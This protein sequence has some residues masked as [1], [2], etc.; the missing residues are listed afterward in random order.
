MATYRLNGEEKRW[1]GAEEKMAQ[2]I[3]AEATDLKISRTYNRL[4]TYVTADQPTDTV[5]KA[6]NQGLELLPL[7]HPNNLYAQ[8][9]TRFKVLLDGKPVADSKI[10]VISGGVR[11]RG[12]LKYRVPI[13]V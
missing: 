1:R 8:E 6:V 12:V 7:S 3:P 11:Y 5:L 10:S 9:T 4:E 2:E 13:T